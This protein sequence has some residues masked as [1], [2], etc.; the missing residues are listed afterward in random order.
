MR[1]KGFKRRT[2]LRVS[3]LALG[4]VAESCYTRIDRARDEAAIQ[5]G[6]V[7]PIPDASPLL[8]G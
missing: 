3:E 1:Y 7:E 2:G 8:E 6:L 4:A 5:Q